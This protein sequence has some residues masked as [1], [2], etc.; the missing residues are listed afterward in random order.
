[1]ELNKLIRQLYALTFFPHTIPP[2]PQKMSKKRIR[3]NYKQCK[4]SLRDNSDMYLQ[5]MTVG[6]KFP[7]IAYFMASPLA[8]YTTFGA[9]DCGYGGKVD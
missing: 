1:M 7:T 5:R 6:D 4:R 3:L 8:K 2:I 9:N